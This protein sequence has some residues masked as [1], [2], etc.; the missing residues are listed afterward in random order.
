[1]NRTLPRASRL[2]LAALATGLC[3]G[4]TAALAQDTRHAAL[5][6]AVPLARVVSATANL[7]RFTETRQQCTEQLQTV[8]AVQP[9]AAPGLGV[10][11]AGALIGGAV[12][13]PIG[14]GNGKTLAIATGSAVGA[15]VA[16]AASERSAAAAAPSYATRSVQVC[17]PVSVVREQVRD[18]TVRY[19]WEG[20]EHLVNLPQHPG[21]WL[22]VSTS[23][24][25]Q[26]L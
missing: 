12:A 7:E 8:Q 23:H 5:D 9:A 2:A 6:S 17:Q 21:P 16:R 4:G 10:T 15:Q 18:Y 26:T 13:A 3:L 1:M 25:V 19:E 22:K 14:K 24:T 20:R 11:L